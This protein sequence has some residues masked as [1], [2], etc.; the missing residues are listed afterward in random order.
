MVPGTAAR[1]SGSVA[2]VVLRDRYVCELC[3]APV[4][5]LGVRS[6]RESRAVL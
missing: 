3:D 6:Y 5:P 1:D 2:T 4:Q